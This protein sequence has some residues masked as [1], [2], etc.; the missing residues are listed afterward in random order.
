MLNTTNITP[1]RVAI[2]DPRTGL[3]TREWYRFLDNLFKLTGEGKNTTSLEDL[4]VGPDAG[5]DMGIAVLETQIQDLA[6]SPV[7]TP[8]IES[9]RYGTFVD[10]TTQTAAAI[11]TAYGM[12][13]NTTQLSNGVTVGTPT[14][15]IYVDRLGVYNIQ[16]SAQLNKSSGTAKN[17][18]IWLRVDGVDQSNSATVVT[19]QGSSAAAVA[20]WNFVVDMNAGS[21][22]ELMW[23]TNDTGCQIT[24]SAA[25]APVP[26]IPSVI[27]TVTNNI[28]SEGPF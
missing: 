19:L 13:F 1:P 21:Y 16:F 5:T 27:L 18:S 24:A 17:V 20:A 10:T 3:I 6:V 2:V 28:K 9:A 22:F 7:N 8:Q 15:R 25:A 14:S 11:N 26:G 23:S 12:T 4:Q